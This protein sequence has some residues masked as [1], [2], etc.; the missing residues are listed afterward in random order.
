M[1]IYSSSLQVNQLIQEMRPTEYTSG[2]PGVYLSVISDR[3]YAKQPQ[4]TNPVAF[5]S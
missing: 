3:L 1:Q 2:L 4:D 5:E